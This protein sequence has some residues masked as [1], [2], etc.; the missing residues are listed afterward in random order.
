MGG[1][2]KPMK[3][4]FSSGARS[5]LRTFEAVGTSYIAAYLPG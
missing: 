2:E 3:Q 4:A 1:R 5:M